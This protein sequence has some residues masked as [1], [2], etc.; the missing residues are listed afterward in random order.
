MDMK[1]Y[2]KKK[3]K[4]KGLKLLFEHKLENCPCG[5]E[6]H[7]PKKFE[8]WQKKYN[9]MV[10]SAKKNINKYTLNKEIEKKYGVKSTDKIGGE[11]KD[12]NY[13]KN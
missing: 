5:A 10:T 12:R 7:K 3:K 1:K 6:Q 4:K 2:K 9:K 13:W 8:E 11:Y